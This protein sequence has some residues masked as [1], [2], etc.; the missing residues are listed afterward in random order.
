MI[1]WTAHPAARR[2][3]DVM[4]VVFVIAIASYAILVGME[5]AWLAAI[6]AVMLV[7]A[8]AP[9]LLRTHYRIDDDGVV[10]RRGFVTRSRRWSELRRLEV[11]RAAALVS[12]YTQR[13]WLDRYRGITIYF[14]GGDRDAVIRALQ[15]RLGA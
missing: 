6:A 14:D 1:S 8:T 4:L 3:Q 9:F 12:P 11:G 7:I 13:R 10:E 15:E 5:S 2:P